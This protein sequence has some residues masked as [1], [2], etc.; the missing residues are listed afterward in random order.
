M[1]D[2]NTVGYNIIKE[3]TKQIYGN[4]IVFMPSITIGVIDARYYE[5]IV[6][7]AYRFNPYILTSELASGFYRTNKKMDKQ[8][9]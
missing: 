9:F 4:D 2:A 6:E 8:S 7:N 1:S 3:S 5:T